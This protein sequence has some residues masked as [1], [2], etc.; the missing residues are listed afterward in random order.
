MS[1][2]RF[3]LT[4]PKP[5]RLN[6]N[7]VERACCDVLRLRGYFVVRLHAGTYRTADSARWIKGVEKGTPD[8]ALLHH[9]YPGFLLEVKRPGAVATPEQK[10]KHEEL[11]IGFQL[12]IGVV[13]SVE[14]LI[15]WLDQHERK[16]HAAQSN[17]SPRHR[18]Q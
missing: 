11:R 15:A 6:E 13:D 17:H 8:Y 1:R 9:R 18:D 12:A 2:P 7:D 3:Q 10:R 4:S 16:S 14:A 5:P